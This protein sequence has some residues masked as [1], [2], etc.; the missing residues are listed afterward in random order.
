M[1][2]KNYI[3]RKSRSGC[4]VSHFGAAIKILYGHGL[5]RGHVC[6]SVAIRRGLWSM[7]VIIYWLSYIL[8]RGISAF[9]T[10]GLVMNEDHRASVNEKLKKRK[11][12]WPCDVILGTKRLRKSILMFRWTDDIMS[13]SGE[14]S[15]SLTSTP[16]L[17][18]DTSKR[19]HP[20]MLSVQNRSVC[21][22]LH[23]ILY[24]SFSPGLGIAQCKRSIM[25]HSYLPGP[26][27]VAQG[28]V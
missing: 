11:K 16:I 8:P 5:P 2:S 1:S 4:L 12:F 18:F 26:G 22:Q 6:L 27:P 13:E 9:T 23:V 25:A 3:Q 17:T 7:P 21:A 15:L 19:S 24:Q 28:P 14:L 20:I 10:P